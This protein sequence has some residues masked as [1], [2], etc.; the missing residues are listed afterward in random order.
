M[1]I[2]KFLQSDA[3]ELSALMKETVIKSNSK[4]YSKTAVR[5]LIDEYTPERLIKDSEKMDIFVA[6][7]K[8]KLLGTISLIDNR[9]S[10]MFVLPKVQGKKIGSKLIKHVETFAKKEGKA[11]LKVRSSLTA[12]GFYQK[13]GYQKTRRASNKFVGPIIWMKKYFRLPRSI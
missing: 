10:I 4:D 11:T 2:R 8:F 12:Y 9:I 13:L 3:E 6:S 1:T 7:E 5:N